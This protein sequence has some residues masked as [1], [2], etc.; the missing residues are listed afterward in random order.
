MFTLQ[1]LGRYKF[2][3]TSLSLVVVSA[4]PLSVFKGHN[5][6]LLQ[7][8]QWFVKKQPSTKD[9]QP[10]GPAFNFISRTKPSNSI[11]NQGRTLL[12]YNKSMME[13]KKMSTQ[14]SRWEI[15][16]QGGRYTDFLYEVPVPV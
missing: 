13:E 4:F 5:N 8:E 3:D 9:E 1:G 6:S 16:Y 2:K 15:L 12:E 7:K 10:P 14:S 11:R